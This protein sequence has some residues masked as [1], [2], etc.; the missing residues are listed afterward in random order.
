[1][2]R[3]GVTPDKGPVLVSGA[4]GGVGGVATIILSQVVQCFYC[5]NSNT[6]TNLIIELP[7]VAG[8]SCGGYGWTE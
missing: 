3:G 7:F 5:H 1:M 4:T 2:E 8:L 6:S